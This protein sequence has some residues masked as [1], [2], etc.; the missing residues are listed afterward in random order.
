[1]TAEGNILGLSVGE[2]L[3]FEVLGHY[4]DFGELDWSHFGQNPDV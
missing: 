1:M 2:C 4:Q 3:M